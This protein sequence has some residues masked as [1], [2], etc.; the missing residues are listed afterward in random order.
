MRT[1]VGIVGAGP[2]GLLLSHLLA[3][4]GIA[5][6]VIEARSR[7]YVE[8]RIR[9]GVLEQGT[10][11]IL[12]EAGVGARM[13]REGL[14]HHGIELCVNGRGHRIDLTELT[15]GRAVMVYAQQ[16]VVKDLIAARLD[17]DGTILFEAEVL[18]IEDH[19]ADRPRIRYRH[20]GEKQILECDFVAGCDGTHGVARS[21]IPPDAL[22]VFERSYP[23]AW[24]GILS[25]SPPPADELIYARHERGFALYSMRSPSVSR[26]YVQCA[27]DD[28]LAA[29]PDE[30]VW[31]ELEARLG[32]EA[33]RPLQRGE[34]Q[35]KA[36]TPMRSFVAEPMQHGR[37]FLAGDSAHI[38]PP[39]GA[40]GLNLA[41][42]DVRILSRAL[43]A[44]Y[45]HNDGT[46]L[47][48][49]SA[50]AL[51]RV[52]RAQHFSWWMTTALHRSEEE[53][54]FDRR[55]HLSQLDYILRS[56]AAAAS[57]AENYTGLPFAD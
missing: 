16:E 9:A 56:S 37:L 5:S 55:L 35:Q 8:G 54:G 28:D 10:I 24:L 32:A 30:R 4:N 57:L 49:Y 46:R 27:P 44:F 29:W 38:V 43:E 20:A 26:L 21:A 17:A 22:T 12:E 45:R 6:V 15:G 19:C 51:W 2:A 48:R 1:Q 42:A 13:R 14:L 41:V 18:A 50:D 53:S 33:G 52:W 34:V 40:K 11:D 47:E 25:Q 39:T 3:L 7:P 31:D 36:I 23:Y